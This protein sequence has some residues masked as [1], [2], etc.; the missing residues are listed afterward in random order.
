MAARGVSR[1][2]LGRD[3]FL[4]EVESWK[5]EKGGIILEQLK[6]LGASLDWSR[7]QFTMSPEFK[8]AVNTAFIKLMDA[9]LIYRAEQ[10]VNWSPLLRSAISDMEVT[11]IEVEGGGVY[12]V[13]GCHTPVQLGTM[14]EIVY[15]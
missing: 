3:K 5:Q 8:Q 15:R 4:A 2:E 14:T 9:G 10:L 6:Q 7:E 13:P 1:H 11:N 12:D